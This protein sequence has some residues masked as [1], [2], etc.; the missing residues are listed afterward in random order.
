MTAC[1]H[2]CVCM[3]VCVCVHACVY[4]HDCMHVCECACARV[5]VCVCV[6]VHACHTH[7]QVYCEDQGLTI[8]FSFWLAREF[9]CSSSFFLMEREAWSS[10]T[11]STVSWIFWRPTFRCSCCSSR[12]LRF[13]LYSF[14]CG[15]MEL[16]VGKA[17]EGQNYT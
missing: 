7:T 2:V 9:F 16:Q 14:T 3:C 1:V 12:S 11:W 4:V 13:S 10:S 5:C 6:N 17:D 8:C 15:G